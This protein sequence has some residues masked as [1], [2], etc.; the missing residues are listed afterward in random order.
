MLWSAFFQKI[1]IA[2]YEEACALDKYIKI[3]P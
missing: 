2:L 3:V 1:T